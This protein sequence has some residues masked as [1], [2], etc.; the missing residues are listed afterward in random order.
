M[1]VLELMLFIAMELRN[2]LEGAKMNNEEYWAYWEQ[3]LK[4][5][6][7]VN[8][9]GKEENLQTDEGRSEKENGSC[10]EDQ[11]S[12]RCQQPSEKQRN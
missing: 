8:F 7:E 11:I 6:S 3:K 5:K 10:I 4:T 9:D 12:S 2:C 1:N